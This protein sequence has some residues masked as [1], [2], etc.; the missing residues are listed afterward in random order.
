M[1]PCKWKK[2]ARTQ[3][4]PTCSWSYTEVGEKVTSL[5]GEPRGPDWSR[6]SL[7]RDKPHGAGLSAGAALGVGCREAVHVQRSPKTF[8]RVSP[9]IGG[10]T[11]C[12][13]TALHLPFF[14]GV[15]ESTL[16]SHTSPLQKMWGQGDG[17]CGT[18]RGLYIGIT[19]LHHA[20]KM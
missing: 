18:R 13:A 6:P 2:N 7:V 12:P 14:L 10:S 19:G 11:S 9:D 16:T 4:C 3:P 15:S 20:S 17:D 1:P 8:L 5:L